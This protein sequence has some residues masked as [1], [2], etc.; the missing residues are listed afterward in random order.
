MISELLLLCKQSFVGFEVS[1]L[2]VFEESG[3]L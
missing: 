3:E 2:D 1:I